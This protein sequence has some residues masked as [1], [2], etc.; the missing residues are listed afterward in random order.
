[1]CILE[2]KLRSRLEYTVTN[3]KEIPDFALG[4]PSSSNEAVT[5]GMEAIHRLTHSA[6]ND[7]RLCLR[8]GERS[9]PLILLLLLGGDIELNPGD[10]HLCS[11]CSKPGQPR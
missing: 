4:F 7:T 2:Q 3:H 8:T 6:K 5:F 11:I 10:N 1:M 9:L